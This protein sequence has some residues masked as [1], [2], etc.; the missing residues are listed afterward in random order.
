MATHH[1]RTRVI[2]ISDPLLK[3]IYIFF[4]ILT[5][6]RTL[7]STRRE[8]FS[9]FMPGAHIHARTRKPV[10]FYHLALSPTPPNHTLSVSFSRCTY[11]RTHPAPFIM[12]KRIIYF[13][14]RKNV[15]KNPFLMSSFDK[16]LKIPP[17]TAAHPLCTPQHNCIAIG[18]H[19]RY[20]FNRP[21]RI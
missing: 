20:S 1:A 9:K 8:Q 6:L 10:L 5:N 4:F 14:Y 13:I 16:I 7:Q 11:T 19:T 17:D 12:R 15:G 18:V 2:I 21:K 3:Y